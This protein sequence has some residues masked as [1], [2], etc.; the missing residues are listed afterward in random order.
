[1][2]TMLKQGITLLNSLDPAAHALLRETKLEQTA[3]PSKGDET[4]MAH[5]ELQSYRLV[6]ENSE[7]KR[8]SQLQSTR[9]GSTWSI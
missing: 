5:S 3:E 4:Y 9:A 6:Q 1:M 7:K 8:W 2:S